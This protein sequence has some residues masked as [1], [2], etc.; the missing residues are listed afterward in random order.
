VN[1]RTL[2]RLAALA[3]L[4]FLGLQFIR[5]QIGNPPVT[6]DFEAPPEVKQILR[7]SCYNCHSYE[8]KLAWFDQIVPAYWLVAKDVKEARRHL[9]FSE[10]GSRPA[11]EQKATLYEAVHMIHFGA[12]PLPSYLRAHPGAVVTDSQLAALRAYLAP[13]ASAPAASPEDVAASDAQYQAWIAAHNTS[14]QLSPAPNGIPF[15][16]DYKNWRAISATDRFDNQTVRVVLANDIA[17]KAASENHINPWPD[18]ATLAKVAWRQQTGAFFQVEFM[19]KDSRKY[20]STLGWGFARW[21]GADLKPYGKDAAFVQECV[22][23]H[24][25]LRKTDYVFTEPVKNP[26]QLRMIRS[27]ANQQNSSMSILFGNDPAVEFARTHTQQRDYPA[28][29]KLALVIWGEREDPRWFGARIPAALKS[30]ELVNVTPDGV[31]YQLLE[32]APPPAQEGRALYLL[33]QRA[34]V[35]P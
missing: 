33:L 3:L 6:A 22:G 7:N 23:C 35:M 27:A 21:R 19:I 14:P 9:N 4:V 15:P 10:L 16:S 26:V 5:P 8:T 28:G 2:I 29:S 17:A 12:M 34:A 31:S 25:P 24:T 30:L 32:G 1:I 13:P 18:G 20:A 11:A